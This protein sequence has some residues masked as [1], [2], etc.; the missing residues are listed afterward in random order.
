MEEMKYRTIVPRFCACVVDA[1]M[2]IPLSFLTKWVWAHYQDIPLM[3]VILVYILSSSSYYI[4][5]IYFLG[6]YGQTPGKMLLKIK[7]FDL[8]ETSHI[9]YYQ[10]LKRDIVLLL[11]TVI[12][13]PFSINQIINGTY[14]SINPQLQFDTNSLIWMGCMLFVAFTWFALD[15]LTAVFSSKHRAIHDYIAG[16]VV[17]KV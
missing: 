5:S 9:T 6:K 17:V 3:V 12:Q 11:A 4:Y 2:F 10:A 1:C 13:L 15:I 16:S 8:S 7:V 14:I